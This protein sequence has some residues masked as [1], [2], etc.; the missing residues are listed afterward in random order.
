M[1]SEYLENGSLFDHLHGQRKNKRELEKNDVSEMIKGI[2]RALTYIHSK[3]IL[4]C[5][6]KSSN[7]LLDENWNIKL[8]DFGLS[9]KII[10][11]NPLED[12]KKA[13]VGTPN[14]MAPE[15]C[16]GENYTDK[17]DI[18]SFGLIVWEIVSKDIPY[19]TLPPGEII[20]QVGESKEFS[21][22]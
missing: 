22:C 5:D 12:Q 21:V 6:L 18:Y 2:L 19:K 3:S 20:H 14:W 10:G 11:I 15:I 16:R 13:R 7:I 9:K 1:I 17:A 4:H 8:A